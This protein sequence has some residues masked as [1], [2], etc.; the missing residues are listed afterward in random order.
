MKVDA[1]NLNN[2]TFTDREFRRFTD[3]YLD[4]FNDSIVD[5]IYKNHDN[6][7]HN[8]ILDG[9]LIVDIVMIFKRN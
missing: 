8:F 2:I 6:N 7:T 9:S 3:E 4:N 5:K 1:K